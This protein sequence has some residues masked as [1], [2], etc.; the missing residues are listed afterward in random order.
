MTSILATILGP[1]L[2]LITRWADK[3]VVAWAS[4]RAA[5]QGSRIEELEDQQERWELREDV[6]ED[7]RRRDARDN[8]EQLRERWTVD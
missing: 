1:V 7:I 2:K 4:W 8:R 3:I 6:E 5:K